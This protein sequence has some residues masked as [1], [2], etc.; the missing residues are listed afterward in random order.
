MFNNIECLFII[1]DH[2]KLLKFHFLIY[3]FIKK[4]FV[5]KLN[6]LIKYYYI[7]L[8]LIKPLINKIFVK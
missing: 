5:F 8:Y 3:V 6:T 7:V 1:H 4:V 2:F